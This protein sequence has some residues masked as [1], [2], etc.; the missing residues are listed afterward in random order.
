MKGILCLTI[1]IISSVLSYGQAQTASATV[2]NQKVLLGE[3]FL[4]KLTATVPNGTSLTWFEDSIPHFEITQRSKVDSQLNGNQMILQ[5]VLTLISFDSGRWN[6]PAITLG[7]AKTKPLPIDVVFTSPFDPNQPYHEIK[8]IIDVPKTGDSKWYWILIGLLLLVIL[9]ALFFPKGKKKPV[10][11]PQRIIREDPFDVAVD[12]LKTLKASGLE[13]TEP[14]RYYSELVDILREYLFHK[15]NIHSFS[16]TTDD[17]AIQMSKLDMEKEAYQRLLQVLR[18]SDGVK[19]ARFQ[20]EV[21]ES[22]EALHV[23]HQSILSIE[24]LDHAV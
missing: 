14:K 23:V 20:P 19:F 5:Q 17:L 6:I 11:V 4:L 18:L 1:F 22:R 7:K 24:D 9:F 21:T 13:A 2:T 12:R 15:K 8:D 3:P 10:P 16:K